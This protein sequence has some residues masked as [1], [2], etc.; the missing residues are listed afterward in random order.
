[1][2]EES[3]RLNRW[4]RDYTSRS[5]LAVG[6][7]WSDESGGRGV[8]ILDGDTELLIGEDFL[9]RLGTRMKIGALPEIFIGEMLFGAARNEEI[10]NRKRVV[11]REAVWIP[12]RTMKFVATE[13]LYL[14]D[15]RNGAMIE[16]SETL[17]KTKSVGREGSGGREKDT[18]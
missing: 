17:M 12:G 16:P 9:K 6:V 3:S 8:L 5:S 10:K 13:P 11:L 18:G 14:E 4:K 1:L 2:A 15:S 7:R